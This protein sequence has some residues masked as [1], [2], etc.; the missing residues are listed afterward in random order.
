MQEKK[1]LGILFKNNYYLRNKRFS[2]LPEFLSTH[3][4]LKKESSNFINIHLYNSVSSLCGLPI[5]EN[6]LAQMGLMLG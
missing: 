6:Q 1:S 3:L 2:G 4:F 5:N